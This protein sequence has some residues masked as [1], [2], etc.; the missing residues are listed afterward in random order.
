VSVVSR[1]EEYKQILQGKGLPLPPE[2]PIMDL[3]YSMGNMDWYAKTPQG[4]YWM[5]TQ[6]VRT[7]EWKHAPMGPPGESP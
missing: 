1:A 4:W 5:R 2:L 6:D 7:Y 3:R